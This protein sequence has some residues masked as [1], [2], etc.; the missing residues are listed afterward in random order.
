MSQ[1]ITRGFAEIHLVVT[2]GYGGTEKIVW[3]GD[4]AFI[5]RRRNLITQASRK[6]L[7]SL[8]THRALETHTIGRRFANMSLIVQRQKVTVAREARKIIWLDVRRKPIVDIAQRAAI[9]NIMRDVRPIHLIKR[10]EVLG[11]IVR[12]VRKV[13]TI[14]RGEL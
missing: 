9:V 7:G 4:P 5:V 13:K 14:T 1:I 6:G 12:N 3:V 2:R 11:R 8:I 10:K